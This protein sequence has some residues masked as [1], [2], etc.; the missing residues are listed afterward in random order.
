MLRRLFLNVIYYF[1]LFIPKHQNWI[2]FASQPDFSDNASAFF[3]FILEKKERN[4]NCKIMHY[5]LYRIKNVKEL[6]NLGI[7]QE[8]ENAIK[9]IDQE[10][11]VKQC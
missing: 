1:D 5:D 10:I 2:L 9:I 4:K 3:K 11:N 6:N 7:F 8:N